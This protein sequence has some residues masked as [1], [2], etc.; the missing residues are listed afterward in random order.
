[1]N[2]NVAGMLRESVAIHQD[3]TSSAEERALVEQWWVSV[4][5][6]DAEHA[7]RAAASIEAKKTPARVAAPERVRDPRPGRSPAPEQARPDGGA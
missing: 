4:G 7:L 1:M 3:P 6:V 2:I 5:V